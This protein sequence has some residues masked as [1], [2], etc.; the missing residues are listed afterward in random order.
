MK[1][2]AP[3]GKRAA[4]VAAVT[5]VAALGAGVVGF[6]TLSGAPPSSATPVAPTR[7][8]QAV[9]QDMS[10]R[11]ALGSAAAD[12]LC[13]STVGPFTPTVVSVPGVIA[14]VPA[15]ALHR[16]PTNVPGVPPLTTAGKRLFGWDAGGMRPG[17]SRGNVNLDAHTWPDGTALGNTLLH[18]LRTG[19]VLALKGAGGHVQCYRVVKQIEVPIDAVPRKVLDRVYARSGSPRLTIIVCSGTRLGPG[20]WTHRTLWYAD[21]VTGA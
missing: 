12:S 9:A 17:A 19:G 11:H 10:H 5:A 3:R 6:R 1:I 8:A 2:A 4:A 18:G 13:R 16:D 20:R 14:A 15:L 7:P 21:A